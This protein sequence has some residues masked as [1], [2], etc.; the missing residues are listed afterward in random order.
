MSGVKLIDL[1][2]TP[3]ERGRQHGEALRT[4]IHQLYAT[5]LD[6]ISRKSAL[7]LGE[8]ELFDFAGNHVPHSK[9][10]A[11]DLHEE[12][13]GIAEGAGLSA[14][15]ILFLNCYEELGRLS[16]PEIAA[17]LCGQPL[18]PGATPATACT[19]FAVLPEATRDGQVYIGQGY[20]M[21]P[22]YEPV[23]LR[24]EAGNE[25]KQLIFTFPGILAAAGMNAAGL[26][27]CE[28]TLISHDQ[29]FGVPNPV[30]V[31]KAL[32]Q[33]TMSDCVGAI[34]GCQ[35]ACGQNY[36]IGS[37][38]ATAD[39]ET[40]AGKHG[41]QY[42]QD[43]VY[44]HANHYETPELKRI[45]CSGCIPDSYMRS[46][47]MLD[48]LKAGTGKLDMAGL[49]RILCDHANF[50]A[51]ICRHEETPNGGSKTVSALV[52]QPADGVMAITRGNPCETAFQEVRI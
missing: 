12:L 44:A 23:V 20:D 6:T 25:P 3:R 46:G 19:A 29:R 5:L 37:T 22:F 13:L 8:R 45:E 52:F 9:Q 31:R 2:G 1:K 30:I 11:P 51:S 36:L 50:P 43:G 42:V 4:E 16:L 33:T 7:R 18:P 21:A 47:R 41:F 27:L 17:R 14:G 39:I 28:N 32:Q 24:I 26:A 15:K 35:R 34:I 10:Y 49:Q 48:L 40:S 38:F